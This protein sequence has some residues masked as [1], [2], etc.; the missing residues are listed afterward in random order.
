MDHLG[1][2]LS[3]WII[4]FQDVCTGLTSKLLA[5]PSKLLAPLIGIVHSRYVSSWIATGVWIEFC[6][7]CT[8]LTWKS[9]APPSKLLALTSLEASILGMFP[10]DSVLEVLGTS[11]WLNS[12]AAFDWIL[13]FL[14]RSNM[15]VARSLIQVARSTGRRKEFR[16]GNNQFNWY[17]FEC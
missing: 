11:Q 14:Y 3:G 12:L 2:S 10:V 7:F 6:Q 16:S 17:W 4:E 15:E 5:P 13:P 1:S 9:L 8:G